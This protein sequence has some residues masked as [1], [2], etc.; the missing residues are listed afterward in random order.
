MKDPEPWQR[1]DACPG[2][3]SRTASV[4][5]P[6]T[7]FVRIGEGLAATSRSGRMVSHRPR[8]ETTMENNL[9]QQVDETVAT[10]K[11]ETEDMRAD[12]RARADEAKADIDAR[13]DAAGDDVQAHMDEVHREATN[14]LDDAAS[15]ASDLGSSVEHKRE[16]AEERLVE[17][18]DQAR[19][20]QATNADKSFFDKIK[21]FFGG[22][23]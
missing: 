20:R 5:A 22:G 19:E 11:A 21:G 4:P 8:K 23:D 10:G 16:E 7:V 15:D 17:M 6:S 3:L 2:N 13:A 12:V 18:L 14:E 1:T 9:K